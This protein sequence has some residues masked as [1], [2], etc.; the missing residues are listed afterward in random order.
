MSGPE[1]AIEF[2]AELDGTFPKKRPGDVNV[3]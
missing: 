1:I 2:I 3:F